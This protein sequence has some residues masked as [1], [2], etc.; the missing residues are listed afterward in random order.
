MSILDK[1]TSGFGHKKE[2]VEAQSTPLPNQSAATT[3]PSATQDPEA[4]VGTD[5]IT[6]HTN[7]Q[8]TDIDDE[9]DRPAEDAQSGVR[10]MQATTLAWTRMSLI[11][12]LVSYV[13][14]H[15]SSS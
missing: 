6:A 1:L 9:K 12:M 14:S 7:D 2:V 3:T 15:F 10:K 5:E 8:G 11:A 13:F 4:Q